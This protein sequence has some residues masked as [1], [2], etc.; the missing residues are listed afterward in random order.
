MAI[1][2]RECIQL[3]LYT[4]LLLNRGGKFRNGMMSQRS[5]TSTRL[6]KQA[7]HAIFSC[8][9]SDLTSAQNRYDKFRAKIG[10]VN[11][12]NGNSYYETW[13]VEI[14][15]KDYN[16]EFDINRVFL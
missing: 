10:W 11:S 13:K 2:G 5:N 4:S 6:R 3:L 7:G 16:N 9:G 1:A 14:L 8:Q 12:Q 15:H